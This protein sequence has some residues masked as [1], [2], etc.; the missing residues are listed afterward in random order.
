[1]T[2]RIP[3]RAVDTGADPL[4]NG[5]PEGELGLVLQKDFDWHDQTGAPADPQAGNIPGGKRDV[6]RSANFND[7]EAEGFVP[8]SGLWAVT[9]GRFEVAPTLLG[10]DAVSVFY[11]DSYLPNYFEI[12]ATIN[13]AKPLAGWK[14]NAFLIFDYVSPTDF[15][16]A[17]VNISLDKIQM[18]HRTADGW[19]VDVQTNIHVRSETNYNL[20]LALN[21]TTATLVVNNQSFFT[22]A[23]APRVDADG[24]TYGL[25]QGMVGIGT[26]NAKGRIDN[27]AV[28]VLPPEV[29]M[30]STDDFST[31]SGL[32]V[33]NVGGWQLGE[34]QY[35]GTPLQGSS[36]AESLAQLNI[37]PAYQL[38]L[39]ML[40]QA[41]STGGVVFDRYSATDFK[42]AA[43][44]LIT[45]QIVIGHY[46]ERRGWVVDAFTSL[47][48]DSTTNYMLSVIL[49]GNVVTVNL[50]GLEVLSKAF[51][52]L[53]VDGEYG[54]LSMNGSSTYDQLTIR[55][56]DP[57]CKTPVDTDD[58]PTLAIKEPTSG[59]VVS[60]YA[61]IITADA[62]DDVGLVKLEFFIDGI[63]IGFGS[64][65]PDGW[66]LPWNST[67]I[68]NGDH[69]LKAVATDTKGLISVSSV[70]IKVNNAAAIDA[71]PIVTITSPANGGKVS[72]NAVSITAN[73]TDD[74][75]V[76]R[77][78]FFVNGNSIGVDTNGSDGWSV[79]W[80]ST[81]VADGNYTLS[82]IATDTNGQQ[83][84][85]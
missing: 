84:S 39:D 7:G 21:G 82:A 74:A 17:G 42:Y 9:D 1:M 8:D 14:S 25:N 62:T 20:L 61:V 85:S 69:I 52:A 57:G 72:G 35:T 70:R 64:N 18:G 73:A 67:L 48:L 23:F 34:G 31:E 59:A 60:G 44:S 16:F 49:K 56:N 76:T 47:P 71:P 12:R 13:A 32:L 46:T 3:T 54:L 81:S 65:S 45:D 24:F 10:G 75:G 4:R 28:Q 58:P 11:V 27:V 50:D 5:E 26:D 78:E 77:V 43:L 38:Q 40:M 53:V 51:N 6:L 22:Y 37:N 2:A 83:T 41:Q 68:A 33:P 29:T 55:T 19:I 80:N 79:L 15:K 66:I 36:L 30:T 63:S